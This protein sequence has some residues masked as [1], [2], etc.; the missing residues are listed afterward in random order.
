MSYV[1]KQ[2]KCEGCGKLIA[3]GE[4]PANVEIKCDCGTL[5]DLSQVDN[6]PYSERL[7]L[8]KK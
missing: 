4:K 3:K 1:K 2:I 7:N 6:R 8:E 5:N